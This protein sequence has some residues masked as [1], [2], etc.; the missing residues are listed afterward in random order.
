MVSTHQHLVES[1]TVTVAKP[2]CRRHSL[3]LVQGR[4]STDP[5][6]LRQCLQQCLPAFRYVR[7]VSS[8]LFTYT[9]VNGSKFCN[10]SGLLSL[11]L[12]S[13]S[14][15]AHP[16][17]QNLSVVKFPR[18]ETWEKL[19]KGLAVRFGRI[20]SA[21][22]LCSQ[23][24]SPPLKRKGLLID[25]EAGACLPHMPVCVSF[26]VSPRGSDHQ[27]SVFHISKVLL[28]RGNS[29]WKCAPCIER[30]VKTIFVKTEFYQMI[31]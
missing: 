22:C 31:I 3:S 8:W 1:C 4:Q 17:R 13:E 9:C 19:C 18:E 6:T 5:R 21:A 15:H 30:N 29:F 25:K 16:Y 26:S 12:S 28:K 2:L 14:V 20:R 7:Q 27:N 11:H 24:E 10:L 23:E